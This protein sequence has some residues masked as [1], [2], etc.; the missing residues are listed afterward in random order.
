MS[1]LVN[2]ERLSEYMAER[3]EKARKLEKYERKKGKGNYWQGY[4]DALV[5]ILYRFEEGDFDANPK[6]ASAEAIRKKTYKEGEIK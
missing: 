3:L 4:V 1:E 6:Q 2:K 5:S